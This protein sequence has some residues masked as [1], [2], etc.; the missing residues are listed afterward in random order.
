MTTEERFFSKVDKQGSDEIVIP[1][2]VPCWWWT[3][4][5]RARQRSLDA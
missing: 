2:L 5:Q 4:Y 1:F 3:A